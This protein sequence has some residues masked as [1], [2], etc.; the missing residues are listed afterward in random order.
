[1]EEQAHQ[2]PRPFH[3]FKV[4]KSRVLP[5]SGFSN[6]P[7]LLVIIAV[8]VFL[9]VWFGCRIEPRSDEIAI[10]IKKTGRNLPQTGQRVLSARLAMSR[11]QAAGLCPPLIRLRA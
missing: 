2:S 6:G 5:L 4:I 1:M 8:A 11:W 3:P 9:F 7:F 10:L